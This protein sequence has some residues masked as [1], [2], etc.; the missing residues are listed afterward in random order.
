MGLFLA[1]RAQ[2]L[3]ENLGR[4]IDEVTGKRRYIMAL[5]VKLKADS[6]QARVIALARQ[7]SSVFGGHFVRPGLLSSGLPPTGAGRD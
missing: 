4:E 2:L 5:P 6:G 3:P 7:A 1:S